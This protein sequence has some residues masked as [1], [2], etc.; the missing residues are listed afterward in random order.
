MVFAQEQQVLLV[1]WLVELMKIVM[2]QRS[3][4]VMAVA[5][6]V[7]N[8]VRIQDGFLVADNAMLHKCTV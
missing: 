2:D 5:L 8:H 3:A 4:V 6:G 1:L 7:F